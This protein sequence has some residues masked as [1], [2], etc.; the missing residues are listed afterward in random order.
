MPFVKGKSGNIKG[1]K[2]GVPNKS[3]GQLREAIQMLIENNLSQ[4]QAV[5]NDLE[6][7]DKLKFLTDLLPFVL[8]KLQSSDIKANIEGPSTLPA[9]ILQGV[10]GQN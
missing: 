5:Y 6:P 7:K 4:V 10:K 3:T 1:R 8:P 2:K 9:V